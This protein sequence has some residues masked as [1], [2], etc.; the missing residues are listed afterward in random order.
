MTEKEILAV[1]L[2]EMT[3]YGFAWRSN[4]N[5]FDGR[6]LRSQLNGIANWAKNPVGDYQNGSDFYVSILMGC[7]YSEEEARKTSIESGG[8]PSETAATF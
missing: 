4:W 6:T 7:D 8:N 1:V 3:Q 5:D 2:R